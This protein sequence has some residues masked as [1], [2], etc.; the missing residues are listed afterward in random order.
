MHPLDAPQGWT[1]PIKRRLR[2]RGTEFSSMRAVE[3]LSK[4]G[5]DTSRIDKKPGQVQKLVGELPDA[6][7]VLEGLRARDLRPPTSPAELLILF[8][9][10]V[11]DNSGLVPQRLSA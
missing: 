1:S 7:R 11:I 9:I 6:R 10:L 2:G 4:V 5:D 8:S 3:A